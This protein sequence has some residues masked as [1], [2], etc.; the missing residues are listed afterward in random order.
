[1]IAVKEIGKLEQVAQRVAPG[2][3]LLRAWELRGGIS[4][5]MTA[6]EFAPPGGGRRKVIVRRPGERAVALNPR[7][8]ADEFKV[9][10]IVRSL[11]VSAQAP[12]WLDESGEIFAEPYLVFEY[13]EGAPEF[14][15]ADVESYLTQVA[16]QLA[17]IH[18]AAA[19]R[20]DLSFLPK[21]AER[22]AGALKGRPPAPDDSLE[23]TRIRDALE[24]VWPLAPLNE[25]VLL[26][27]DFWPGNL[28][29]KDGRLVAVIDWEDA[30]VGDP[31]ADF[32][33]SR[34]EMLWLFGTDAMNEF[35]HR[36]Q[37]A[38]AIDL[39]Q[40]PYWDLYAALRPASCIGEWAAEW[41]AL[42]RDDV[43][44]ATMR[45]GHRQFVAQAFA[46]LPAA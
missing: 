2:S 13:L 32:A 44:E 27:G 25:A 35:T 15:P 3:R 40:L 30:E 31:L 38:A 19:A 36:Y 7:A 10:Q 33:V 11:G 29:W 16:G 8:A 21:Q 1:M 46:R 28:L 20:A 17:A 41:P 18:S 45:E 23:E 37:S 39:R 4:A 12:T 26:H 22:L 34:L 14:A 5:Q 9:L 42:G 43:T 6:L 24:A